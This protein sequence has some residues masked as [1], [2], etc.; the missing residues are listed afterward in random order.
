MNEPK[1]F[2]Y[3]IKAADTDDSAFE[4]MTIPADFNR[5]ISAN[6]PHCLSDCIFYYFITYQSRVCGEIRNQRFKSNAG[7][8]GRNLALESVIRRFNNIGV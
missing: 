6:E 3:A 4:S 8:H 2:R 7:I 5:M 1:Q